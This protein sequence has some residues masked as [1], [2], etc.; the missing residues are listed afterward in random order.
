MGYGQKIRAARSKGMKT[1]FLLIPL[2]GV[3]LF[4]NARAELAV[5]DEQFVKKAAQGGMVEVR[6]GE[7]AK[8]KATK[9]GVKDFGAMMATDHSKANADLIALAQKK[10]VKL[11]TD[12]DPKHKAVV[13][14]LSKL[15]GADFDKAYVADMVEDHKKDI[16]EFEEASRAVKDAELKAFA[17][18][19]LPTLRRHLER[20][21]TL[22]QELPK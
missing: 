2:A 22:Q 21:Q 4:C 15:S 12:L 18:K 8:Q 19:T 3:A 7:L 20:I 17:E 11:S 5:T 10:G 14:R 1:K 9:S 16:A 6:L 13:E